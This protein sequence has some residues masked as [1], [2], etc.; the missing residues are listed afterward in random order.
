VGALVLLALVAAACGRSEASFEAPRA[1]CKA[2]AAYEKELERQ[3]SRGEAVGAKQLPYVERIAATA[4]PRIA[5]DAAV[6]LAAMQRVVAD[7]TAVDDPAVQRAVTN[8]NRYY[9]Q[10]CGVYA[11]RSGL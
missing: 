6:F 2:G 4:P 11:R 8:V 3:Q 1:F 5:D 7:P 9:S 10:G